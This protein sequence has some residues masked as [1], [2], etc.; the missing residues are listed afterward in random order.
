VEE[1]RSEVIASAWAL[2]S[3]SIQTTFSIRYSYSS[4]DLSPKNPTVQT[5]DLLPKWLRG[6]NKNKRA[7]TPYF[8]KTVRICI[9]VTISVT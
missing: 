9:G 3:M 5:W 6:A 8:L 4:L 1:E 2:K 7:K